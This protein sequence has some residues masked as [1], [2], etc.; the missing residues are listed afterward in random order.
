MVLS[1]LISSTTP[2]V[3]RQVISAETASRV[4]ALLA[5]AVANGGGKNAYVAGYRVAGKTGT[6]EK[7]ETGG[8]NV[9]AS[10][11]GFAPADDPQLA[12]LVM[13]DEPQCGNR[14]GG[15]IAAPVAKKILEDALQYLGVEPKYTESEMADMNVSTP[16]VEGMDVI[17][18]EA[19]IASQGLTCRVMGDGSMVIKQIPEAGQ[20]IPKSGTVIVYTDQ[21]SYQEDVVTVPDFTGCSVSEAASIAEDCGLNLQFSGTGLDSGEAIAASQ[22]VTPGTIVTRG[23]IVTVEFI[24]EDH[25]E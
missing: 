20:S 6:S 18:A 23:T 24:Y 2:T 21:S 7:T 8:E 5:N 17:T 14:Y 25:I 4:S 1:V 13:I 10:F 16:S 12:V 22:S 19:T 11:G 15:T 3:K 9:V